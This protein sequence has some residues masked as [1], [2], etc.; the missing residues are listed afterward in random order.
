MKGVVKMVKIPALA[1]AITAAYGGLYILCWVVSAV[2]PD[3][4]FALGQSW[5]HNF[6]LEAI[7]R[8]TSLD[9]GMMFVGGVVSSALIW[10]FTYV[11]GY[12]YN[13]WS[14]LSKAS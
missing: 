1:N 6:N 3:F 14:K 4:L 5:F 9:G 7:R 10:G 13:L 2:A 12:L 11:C 8:T